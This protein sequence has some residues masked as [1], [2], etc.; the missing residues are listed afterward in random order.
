MSSSFLIVIAIM[1]GCVGVAGI[2]ERKPALVLYG[3][4]VCLAQISI[5]WGF[6]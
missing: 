5:I 1:F 6:E 2:L 4:S 3:F